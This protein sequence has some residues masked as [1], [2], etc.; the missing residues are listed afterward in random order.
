MLVI[1]MHK[2]ASTEHRNMVAYMDK[3]ACGV[4]YP[5][6][7]AEGIQPGEIYTDQDSALFWHHSGFAFLFGPCEEAFLSC[8]YDHFLST[9]STLSRRFVLFAENEN[10]K[11]F[12]RKKKNLTWG[13][14][15]FFEY[16]NKS[17]KRFYAGGKGLSGNLRVCEISRELLDKI[18]G[19]ITPYFSWADSCAFLR[20]GKG[21]CVV[22]GETA[23][24]WAFSAAVSGEEMDIG[25]ETKAAYRHLGLGTMVSERMVQYCLEQHKR[26]VWACSADNAASKRLAEKA[27]F[28]KTAECETCKRI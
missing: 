2:V 7:I 28:L 11:Q 5:L 6:S 10:V 21:Y 18:E 4:V 23:A 15:Y 27:G 1:A 16:P 12:F 14:R 17:A 3:T 19:T 25:V 26:P 9:E 24:A 8:V 20:R 22:D 13:K